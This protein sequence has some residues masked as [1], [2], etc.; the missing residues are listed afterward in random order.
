MESYTFIELQSFEQLWI[1]LPSS[2]VVL[3]VFTHEDF[4][5][6]RSLL[7]SVS[8]FL[9]N[10]Y[11]LPIILSGKGLMIDHGTGV[12]IGETAV[13]G[14]N[15]SFL[16][17]VTLGSTGKEKGDRHPKIGDDVLIGC[18]TTVLGNISI[19]S[20]CKIGSGS[21]VLKSL[22]KGMTAV[23]NPARVVGKSMCPSASMGMDLAL[24]HVRNSNGLVYSTTWSVFA[25]GESQYEI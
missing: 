11:N 2:H 20:C 7:H 3:I 15:C 17:G 23:G 9:F 21:I 5:Y 19:G 6:W 22:P 10:R 8:Q 25:E 4:E 13:I 18:N 12:V 1:K 24:E 16:H 14:K